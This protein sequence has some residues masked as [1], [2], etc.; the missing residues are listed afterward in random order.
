MILNFE[1]FWVF[2]L[3]HLS[4]L[5]YFRGNSEESIDFHLRFIYFLKGRAQIAKV[6]EIL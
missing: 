6:R 1:R 3:F 2:F 5:D 4:L